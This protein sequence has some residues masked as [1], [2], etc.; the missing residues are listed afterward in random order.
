MLKPFPKVGLMFLND[1][2]HAHTLNASTFK[3]PNLMNNGSWKSSAGFQSTLPR[4]IKLCCQDANGVRLKETF[5]G[6]L[7]SSSE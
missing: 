3:A 6:R 4:C 7:D 5:P 2:R 1:Q